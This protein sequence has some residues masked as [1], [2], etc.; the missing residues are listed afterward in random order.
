MSAPSQRLP[1][2]IYYHHHIAL[3]DMINVENMA[4]DRLVLASM[5]GWLFE[6]MQ[7]NED[8][9]TSHLNTTSRLVNGNSRYKHSRTEST[10]DLLLQI[11]PSLILAEVYNRSVLTGDSRR[12]IAPV[13]TEPANL[14]GDPVSRS[15]VD[16]RWRI[17]DRITRYAFTTATT[18]ESVSVQKQYLAAWRNA[19][20]AYHCKGPETILHKQLIEL[21]INIGITLLPQG[22][23]AASKSIASVSRVK[24]AL[25]P[26][27]TF[28]E[29][30]SEF[31][32]ADDHSIERT[33]LLVLKFVLYNFRAEA[34]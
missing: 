24:D 22:A 12:N 32:Q 15:L 9:A 21:L 17:S 26:V 11:R 27:R 31:R 8:A 4:Y 33:L 7:S 25:E 6:T 10:D 14:R 23:T 34:C 2:L 20:T 30:K 19:L 18:T 28:M 1:P 16:A 5:M 3:Q 29:K 13:T